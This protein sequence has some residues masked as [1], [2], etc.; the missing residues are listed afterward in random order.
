MNGV[1]GCRQS[2]QLTLKANIEELEKDPVSLY[3]LHRCTITNE[4]NKDE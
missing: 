2:L 1:A 4:G 3:F